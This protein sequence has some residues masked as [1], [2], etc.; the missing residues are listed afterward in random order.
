LQRNYFTNDNNY[1]YKFTSLPL[2]G[3]RRFNG[4]RICSS[5]LPHCPSSVDALGR[6]ALTPRSTKSD[7]VIPKYAFVP[8]GNP[9]FTAAKAPPEGI[10]IFRFTEALTFPNSVYIDD[11]LV[12]YTEQ[13]TRRMYKRPENKGDQ[14]WNESDEMIDPAKS[15]MLPQLRA[16]IYDFSAVS[17]IDSSGF[18]ALLDI[19]RAINKHAAYDVEYHFVNILDERVQFA[20]VKAG[21]GQQT[22]VTKID[23][24]TE[25]TIENG[26]SDETSIATQKRYFHLTIEEAIVEAQS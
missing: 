13:N 14:P 10:L 4:T 25:E 20:L 5:S 12:K 18:Q 16:V 11:E 19:K 17:I 3:Y 6:L 24:K 26:K 2:V 7:E 22:S 1:I 15:A 8:L 9:S 21:F 23:E